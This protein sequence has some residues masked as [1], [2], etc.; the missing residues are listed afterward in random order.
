[1]NS[2]NTYKVKSIRTDGSFYSYKKSENGSYDDK[3]QKCIE[4]TCKY[5]IDNTMS[6]AEDKINNP[7]MMLGKIQ[8]GKT[9]DNSII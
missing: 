9:E 6:P 1:M 8:S 7:I 4:D 5:C 3:L 2:H